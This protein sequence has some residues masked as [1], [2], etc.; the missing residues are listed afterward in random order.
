MSVLPSEAA[1]WACIQ[2]PCHFPYCHHD[3]PGSPCQL[4]V[5]PHGRQRLP[6]GR[7]KASLP[8]LWLLVLDSA[9]KKPQTR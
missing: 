1:G 8:L 3:L 2:L 6:A 7:Q 4:L 5:M 9:A